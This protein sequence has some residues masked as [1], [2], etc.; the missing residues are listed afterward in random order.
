MF[1]A[2]RSART[3]IPGLVGSPLRTTVWIPLTPDVP[4]PPAAAAGHGISSSLIVAGPLSRA[5]AP[6]VVIVAA[7]SVAASRHCRT[8]REKLRIYKVSLGL[9]NRLTAYIIPACF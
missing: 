2:A 4:A 1:G 8:T 9:H 3:Y 5:W 7:T 6:N